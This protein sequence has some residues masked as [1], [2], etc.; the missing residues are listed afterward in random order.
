MCFSLE[1]ICV[2]TD[3]E[4]IIRLKA[5]DEVAFQVIYTHYHKSLYFLAYKYLKEQSLAEDALQDVFL[6]LWLSRHILDEKLSLKGFLFTSLKNYL[7]NAL[8]NKKNHAAKYSEM[9][10]NQDVNLN[11]T[12]S[13][14]LLKEYTQIVN[15]GIEKMSP[16]KQLIFR[17]RTFKGLKNEEIASHLS[18]S[19]NTV[20]FQLSQATKFLR[21]Y[22]K[23]EADI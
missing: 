12:E 19:I 18:I 7:L 13:V 17:L 14:F 8:R 22:L 15:T 9:I 23:N 20:K 16:Q 4:L 5:G 3:Q 10:Y 6:K 1:A 21:Q 2:N 11:G